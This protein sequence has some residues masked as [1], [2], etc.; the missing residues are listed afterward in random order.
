MSLGGGGGGGAMQELQQQLEA[1]EQEKRAIEAEIEGD[2]ERQ[3]A[4]DEAIEAIETL[5]TGSTVQVP[6]GCGA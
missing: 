6:L 1:L 4:I 5:E 2:R 3:S